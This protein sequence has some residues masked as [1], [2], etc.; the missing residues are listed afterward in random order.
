MSFDELVPDLVTAFDA[1]NSEF[2]NKLPGI[3]HPVDAGFVLNNEDI[4]LIKAWIDQGAE[5]N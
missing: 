4:A 1:E 2:V 3:G 5:N